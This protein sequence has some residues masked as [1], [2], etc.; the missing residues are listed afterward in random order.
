[1]S[2]KPLYEVLILRTGELDKRERVKGPGSL[3]GT[4]AVT[5]RIISLLKVWQWLRCWVIILP[6]RIWK[7]KKWNENCI[8][9]QME[10]SPLVPAWFSIMG[11]YVYLCL[12]HR[13]L[14]RTSWCLCK[15]E[16]LVC[17]SA[18]SMKPVFVLSV[19][20][21]KNLDS[22]NN[23]IHQKNTLWSIHIML[24]DGSAPIWPITWSIFTILFS[25]Y[26]IVYIL[27]P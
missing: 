26:I 23:S 21:K 20:Q 9:I 7:S 18:D 17:Y 13:K 4:E 3:G 11:G 8:H 15:G 14:D 5:S 16:H 6:D 19:G 22:I 2:Q 12:L 24:S 27:H 1:M 25:E 10:T